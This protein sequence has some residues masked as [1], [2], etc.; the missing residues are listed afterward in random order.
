MYLTSMYLHSVFNL[1]NDNNVEETKK[2]IEV[3]KRVNADQI[4]RNRLKLVRLLPRIV[5]L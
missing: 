2:E 5:I 4:K 3:Y 1:S